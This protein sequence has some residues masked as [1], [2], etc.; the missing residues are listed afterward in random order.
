MTKSAQRKLEI[1]VEKAF[2]CSGPGTPLTALAERIY[3]DNPALVEILKRQCIVDHLA[4]LLSLKRRA[5]VLG[6]RGL[7]SQI[8]KECNVS[9]SLVSRV[10]RLQNTSERVSRAIDAA[11]QGELQRHTDWKAR[12]PLAG[13]AKGAGAE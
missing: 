7:V 12:L 9:H 5:F 1:L 3:E 11:I 10:L 6:N 4:F 2:L 8:A 13:S